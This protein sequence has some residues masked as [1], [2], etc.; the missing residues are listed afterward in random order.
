MLKLTWFSDRKEYMGGLRRRTTAVVRYRCF[1]F[2]TLM[3]AEGR[4]VR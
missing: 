4:R 1:A 3:A 2:P